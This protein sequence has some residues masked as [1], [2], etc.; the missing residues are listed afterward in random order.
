MTKVKFPVEV[1]H[2]PVMVER[3]RLDDKLVDDLLF[4]DVEEAQ[5]LLDLKHPGYEI[6][7]AR[8]GLSFIVDEKQNVVLTIKPAGEE[9]QAFL[10]ANDE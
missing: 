3:P 1:A 7:V 4:L 5:S 10:D 8:S 9:I 6:A 2:V